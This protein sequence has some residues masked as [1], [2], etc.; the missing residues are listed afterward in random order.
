MPHSGKPWEL[1]QNETLCRTEGQV[2]RTAR[3]FAISIGCGIILANWAT[4]T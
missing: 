4:A 2:Y 1:S 3:V